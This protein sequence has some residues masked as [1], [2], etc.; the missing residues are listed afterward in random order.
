M[1]TAALGLMGGSFDPIH[2][3]HVALARAAL[4]QAGLSSVLFLVSGNP[5]HKR[6]LGAPAERRLELVRLALMDEPWAEASDIELRPGTVYTVDTLRLLRARLP[7]TP[8][9]YIVGADTVLDM[10]S[11][12][13]FPAVASLCSFLAAMRGGVDEEAVQAEAERLRSLYGA[14]VRFLRGLPPAVSSTLVRERLQ[15]GLSTEGLLHPAVR[16][17][18][19][20]YRLYAEVN[21]A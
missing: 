4:E 5:P 7:D 16:A 1:E 12:R 15:A 11:W 14:R 2:L 19:D 20:R 9:C 3:G 21:P 10:H 13:D 6:A 18:I 17:C 8:L